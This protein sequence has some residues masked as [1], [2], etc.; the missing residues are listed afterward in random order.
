MAGPTSV[1]AALAS[2]PPIS[3][4]SGPGLGADP[5]RF[6][7]FFLHR[8][9]RRLLPA[10]SPNYREEFPAELRG[11][12]A[13]EY[14][15]FNYCARRVG[16]LAGQRSKLGGCRRMKLKSQAH[17]TILIRSRKRDTRRSSCARSLICGRVRIFSAR[18]FASGAGSHSRFTN[19]SRT[20]VLF[21]STRRSLRAAIVKERASCFGSRLIDLKNPPRRADGE[22]DYARDFF[23]RSTF[24]TV[25]G[26]LEAEAFACALSKVYTFGPDLSRGEFKH[27]PARERVL[28]DRAGNGVLRSAAATWMWLKRL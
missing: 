10:Q 18:S 16:P 4:H 6:E 19:F 24:L 23:A 11:R 26:Q 21:T 13:F 22:I 27:F 5:A 8:A 28:D 3:R 2:P 14:G 9:E 17:R 25:S 20:A 1:K 7:G 15:R 12:P